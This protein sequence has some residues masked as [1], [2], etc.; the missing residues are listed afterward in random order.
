MAL[1]A[2]AALAG[3]AGGHRPT[4]VPAGLTYDCSTGPAM[5]VFNGGG[6]LPDGTVRHQDK[7]G[8]VR[9]VPRSTALLT[10]AGREHRM[11]A[12]AAENGLRYRSEEA[13][14][15]GRYLV[16][17]SGADDA[18]LIAVSGDAPAEQGTEISTC[19]RSGRGAARPGPAR[20][21]DPHLG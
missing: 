1:P 15:G 19:T 5:I 10:F 13:V 6:Y 18:R 11:I 8:A 3:C 20:Q 2:L 17:T 16:W 9:Q 14:E 21:D 12:E 7:A 4:I